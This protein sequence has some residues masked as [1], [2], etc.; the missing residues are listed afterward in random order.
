[1]VM[2]HNHQII[3]KLAVFPYGDFIHTGNGGIDIKKTVAAYLQPSF[4]LA[5]DIKRPPVLYFLSQRKLCPFV[6]FN[7]GFF[8]P[9]Q[10]A[11]LKTPSKP[12]L[13]KWH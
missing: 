8:K 11:G 12:Q 13:P 6:N 2:V 5:A 10:H 7:P 9:L 4:L 1:M 3:A